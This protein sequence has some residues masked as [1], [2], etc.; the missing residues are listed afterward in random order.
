MLFAEMVLARRL[1]EQLDERHINLILDALEGHPVQV[2]GR[3]RAA[4]DAF[5]RAIHH[6]FGPTPAATEIEAAFCEGR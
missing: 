1:V 5:V 2:D 3:D 4:I 6:E